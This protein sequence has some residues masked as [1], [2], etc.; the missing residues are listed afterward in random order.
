MMNGGT[1]AREAVFSQGSY[2][3]L[4]SHSQL[5]G[6]ISNSAPFRRFADHFALSRCGTN[7][8]DLIRRAL[9][10]CYWRVLAPVSACQ[11]LS[12]PASLAPIWP[13]TCDCGLN[14]ALSDKIIDS[15]ISQA[16]DNPNCAL[17]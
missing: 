13:S 15:R 16:C 9:G 6:R 7:G 12:A 17:H 8:T 3:H 4:P 5:T 1:L 11:R 2:R 10:S 14:A